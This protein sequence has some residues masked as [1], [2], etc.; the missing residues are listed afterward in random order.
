M[1]EVDLSTQYMG[2]T[3]KNPIIAGASSLTS[4]MESIRK[5]EES[6]VG[7]LVVKSLFEEQI[8]LEEY[9]LANEL[10]K[11]DNLH[12]EM[13][14]VFPD[15]KHA[16]PEEHLSWV[17]KT[18]E[19]LSIPVIGSLNAVNKD[20]WV[21]YAKQLAQTGIDML[22]LNIYELDTNI[23][24]SAESIEKEQVEAVE[25][26]VKNLDIPI[27]VKIAP[28][29]TS[30][31][32]FIRRLSDAGASGLVLFN[33]L[34]QPSIN[35]HRE[36]NDYS[37]NL[38]GAN[39]Y[40]VPLRFAGLLHGRIDADVCA[41]GGIN[42]ADTVI[43]TMLAGA[44]AVQMV[45]ALYSQSMVIVPKILGEIK[46]WMADKGYSSPAEFIGK[47]SYKNNPHPELYTRAQYARALLHPD[48]YILFE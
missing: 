22:E 19:E 9:R 46:D 41:S 7:A 33:R 5:L 20:M 14:T 36:E 28:Y 48:R 47:M 1:A 12:P 34:F 29:Y 44:S 45:S 27:A 40:R 17:R 8:K 31:L 21:D 15:L 18:K 2:Q 10:H 4:R 16:G 13:L 11:D 6:G 24:R 32:N 26:V 35:H 25:E 42:S 30:P 39:A 43:K 38:S 23:D 3:L 37:L